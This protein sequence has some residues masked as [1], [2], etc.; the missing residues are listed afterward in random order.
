V[1][2]DAPGFG[3]HPAAAGDLV[4]VH[5]VGQYCWCQGCGGSILACQVHSCCDIQQVCGTC[6]GWFAYGAY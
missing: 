5:Y 4:L 2:S 1:V 6:F 3:T